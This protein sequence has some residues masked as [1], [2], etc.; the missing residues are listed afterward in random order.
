MGRPA[1]LR[2]GETGRGGEGIGA[3]L[4]VPLGFTVRAIF[5]HHPL[6]V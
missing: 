1:V 2:G 6:S 5:A 4:G 3:A